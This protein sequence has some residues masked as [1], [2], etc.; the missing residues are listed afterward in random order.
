MVANG[1]L[2][3]LAAIAHGVGGCRCCCGG[4]QMLFWFS[5][6]SGRALDLSRATGF[7]G[8]PEEDGTRAG[9]KKQKESLNCNG[10]KGRRHRKGK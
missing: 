4:Q 6:L 9:G 8:P 2:V 5:L 10:G 7:E 3:A 1:E